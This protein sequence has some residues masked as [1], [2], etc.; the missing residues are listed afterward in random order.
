[1]PKRSASKHS[2]AA[3]CAITVQTPTIWQ[4]S[5]NG[6]GMARN[7]DSVERGDADKEQR[8]KPSR[9]LDDGHLGPSASCEVGYG[10]AV[11]QM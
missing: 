5:V 3:S 7:S 11:R 6:D 10:P 2:S 4:T 8:Q 9:E 1:M